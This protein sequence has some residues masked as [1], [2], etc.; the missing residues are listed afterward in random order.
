MPWVSR[1]IAAVGGCSPAAPGGLASGRGCALSGVLMPVVSR[2]IAAVGGSCGRFDR[3]AAA[4]AV[5]PVSAWLI[6]VVGGC[7]PMVDP[8]APGVGPDP[9]SW[10]VI[11]FDRLSI[12]LAHWP[13]PAALIGNASN[14]QLPSTNAIIFMDLTSTGLG[15]PPA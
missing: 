1:V 5:P 7:W 2:F 14:A 3:L 12:S 4:D 13:A 6:A 10:A 11:I 8:G 9:A 15:W